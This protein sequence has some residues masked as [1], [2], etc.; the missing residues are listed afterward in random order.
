M[1]TS[2]FRK[3]F[4]TC[5]YICKKKKEKLDTKNVTNKEFSKLNQRKKQR[6]LLVICV[7]SFLCLNVFVLVFN[8][9]IRVCSFNFNIIFYKE[10]SML[11]PIFKF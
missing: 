6:K 8:Q 1:Q 9:Y 2:Q 10:L 3:Y 7:S 4:Y 11:N 5:I